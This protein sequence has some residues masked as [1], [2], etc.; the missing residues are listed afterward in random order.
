MTHDDKPSAPQMIWV[1][2]GQGEPDGS[3]IQGAYVWRKD[4]GGH[5]AYIR[6]LEPKEPKS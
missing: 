3:L 4:I 1:E 5:V 6:S 2:F